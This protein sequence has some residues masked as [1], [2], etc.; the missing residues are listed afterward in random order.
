MKTVEHRFADLL[1][2][3]IL[4]EDELTKHVEKIYQGQGNPYDLALR[5]MDSLK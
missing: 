1:K 4:P 3:K 5:I 2:N